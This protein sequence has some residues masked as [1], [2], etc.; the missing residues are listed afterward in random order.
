MRNPT[1]R[2]IRYLRAADIF[3]D[4]SGSELQEIHHF[5]PMSRCRRG[6]II[7]HSGEE[8]ERLY[9]LKKGRVVLYRV[10]SE[11]RRT[12]I[13]TVKP[14]TVFGELTMAGLTMRDC[15]AETQEDSLVCEATRTD[16]QDLLVTH[17]KVAYR[18]IETLGRRVLELEQRL[19]QVAF[20]SVRARIAALLLQWAEE[21]E[22]RLVLR[23]YR[24]E[25]VA[26]AIGA[27][28]QTV[29]TEL[30]RLALSGVVDRG[31]KQIEIVDRSSLEEIAEV[32][33]GTI[34][35]F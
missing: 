3:R 22:G 35:Y 23:G 9:I 34:D 6:T 14:G 2:S 11:G 26:D 8:G 33:R 16:I 25:D 18:L 29:S 4:L 13:G 20:L 27:A 28:R 32:H 30:K 31:R 1:P 7:F 15:Y 24:Q 12:V 5:F 17:P 21:S 10:T 19:E